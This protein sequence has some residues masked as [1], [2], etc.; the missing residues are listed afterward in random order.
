[1][2]SSDSPRISIVPVD[3]I[4]RVWD[5]VEPMLKKAADISDGRFTIDHIRDMLLRDQNHL[6]VVFYPPMRVVSAVTT[7]FNVYPGN[8]WLSVQFLGGEEM[9]EWIGELVEVMSRWSKDNGCAGIECSGRPGWSRVLLP[10]GFLES[11][12]FYQK[13]IG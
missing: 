3:Q 6:W 10:L 5:Q 7:V 8:K 9:R 1:M 4:G 13:E 11:N 2:D 12:R